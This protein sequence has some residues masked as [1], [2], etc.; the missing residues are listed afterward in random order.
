MCVKVE[1][2]VWSGW[3]AGQDQLITGP[4]HQSSEDLPQGSAPS[5]KKHKK[6]IRNQC[7]T[8]SSHL[9]GQSV[10]FLRLIVKKTACWH[11]IVRPPTA[12]KKSKV[13]LKSLFLIR[14]YYGTSSHEGQIDALPSNIE[15]KHQTYYLWMCPFNYFYVQGIVGT[16]IQYSTVRP[17]QYVIKTL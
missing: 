13:D 2:C 4:R 17:Y 7:K 14:K 16:A 9:P 10:G 15:C 5:N 3:L 6:I 12:K 1:Q 11:W 8:I